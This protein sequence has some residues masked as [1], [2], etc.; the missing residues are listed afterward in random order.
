MFLQGDSTQFQ[1]NIILQAGIVEKQPFSFH[2]P[3]HEGRPTSERVSIEHFL[4]QNHSGQISY[5]V[6]LGVSV[7]CL[8]PLKHSFQR[9]FYSSV[10]L[11]L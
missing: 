7:A 8:V 1:P 2:Q 9:Q 5:R 3:G 11:I 10:G 4:K 6:R